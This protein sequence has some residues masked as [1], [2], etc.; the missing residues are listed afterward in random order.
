MRLSWLQ[1]NLVILTL[2]LVSVGCSSGTYTNPMSPHATP[3]AWRTLT[4]TDAG[5]EFN[6]PDIGLYFSIPAGAVL[7]D[8][9]YTFNVR[10][11]PSGIPLV[12][13]GPVFVRLATF[14]LVGGPEDFEFELPIEVTFQL[15]EAR[16]PGISTSGY[17]LNDANQWEFSQVA[18]ILTDGIHAIMSIT[19]PG[20][21]GSFMPIPLHVEIKVSRSSGPIPL[22]VGFEALITGGHPPYTVLWQ[23]GDNEDPDTGIAISHMYP[24]PGTYTCS[25]QVYDAEMHTAQDWIN[26]YAYAQA[27]P[28]T[29]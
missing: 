7:S 27:G 1:I 5:G 29:F 17:A 20:V 2:I 22:S 9:R 3:T 12:P 8:E 28:T 21:Y 26:V 14:E 25:A 15:I 23:W 4:V 10:G 6:F 16:S 19:A 18:P 11:F 24:D 13:T